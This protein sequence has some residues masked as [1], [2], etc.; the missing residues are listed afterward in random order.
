VSLA[1][2][3]KVCQLQS[4]RHILTPVHLLLQ[5]AIGSQL[6]RDVGAFSHLAHSVDSL[7]ALTTVRSQGLGLFRGSEGFHNCAVMRCGAPD[8]LCNALDTCQLLT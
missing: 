6:L 2:G 4:I 3:G 5:A 7:A 1:G 8:L